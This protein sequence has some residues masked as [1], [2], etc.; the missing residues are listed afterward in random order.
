MRPAPEKVITLKPGQLATTID[1]YKDQVYAK[2]F[3]WFWQ[4]VWPLCFDRPIY[5]NFFNNMG[6]LFADYNML[7]MMAA[8]GH[9]KSSGV[10]AVLMHRLFTVGVQ[11]YED[12]ILYLSGTPKQAGRHIKN[13]S[14]LIK[15]NPLFADVIDFK[16]TAEKMLKMGEDIEKILEVGSYGIKQETRGARTKLIIFDDI[17]GD[18]KDAKLLSTTGVELINAY[19]SETAMPMLKPDDDSQA[20]FV[21]TSMSEMDLFHSPD[22]KINFEKCV[23]LPAL[24][25]DGSIAW[26]E[27]F[28]KKWVAKRKK[29]RQAWRR[30]Y[31]LIPARSADSYLREEWIEEAVDKKLKNFILDAR[32]DDQLRQYFA[33]RLIYAGWDPASRGHA[34]SF[35]ILDYTDHKTYKM[36]GSVF[37]DK[38]P[39]VDQLER[40]KHL[41]DVFNIESV[42]YD[43]TRDPYGWLV[44]KGNMDI[45]FEGLKFTRNSK[46]EIA[47]AMR[48]QFEMGTIKLLPD[49]R[50]LKSLRMVNS[51]LD[52]ATIGRDHGDAFWALALAI[53]NNPAPLEVESFDVY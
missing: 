33:D 41:A 1:W 18:A 14:K 35:I 24:N 3:Y 51:E 29:M 30:E 31:M 5:G 9:C 38:M 15:S 44:E 21:G 8:R 6:Q 50:L 36:V 48:L 28:S 53:A 17:Y 34:S 12:E 49:S 13:C 11:Q 19:A 47:S 42:Q 37:W 26:G 39:L 52:A 45:R 16:P 2:G 23:K 25:P 40:A 4:N 46:H 7:M 22:F 10:Y 20:Y 27:M 32:L 43:E